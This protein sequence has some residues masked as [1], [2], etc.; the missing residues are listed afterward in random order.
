MADNLEVIVF[1]DTRD[2]VISLWEDLISS[3]SLWKPSK[4]ILLITNPSLRGGQHKKLLINFNTYIDIDP[5]LY[6][7]E[8]LRNRA[9]SMAKKDHVN[10]PFPYRGRLGNLVFKIL[11]QGF[12]IKFSGGMLY[13]AFEGVI[14]PLDLPHP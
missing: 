8:W 7:A 4:T 5:S 2:V 12:L 11:V 13:V 6:D 14:H 3:T 9:Q 10:L 1:D